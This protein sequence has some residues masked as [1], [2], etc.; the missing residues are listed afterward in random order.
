MDLAIE[1]QPT[2]NKGCAL[3]IKKGWCDMR[4][5]NKIVAL[6]V[7][8]AFAFSSISYA[9]ETK[10]KTLGD[11]LKQG[12]SDVYHGKKK[13]GETATGIIAEQ[14]QQK[15]DEAWKNSELY[16]FLFSH[17]TF[18]TILF[19]VSGFYWGTLMLL[20]ASMLL[21]YLIKI[22][23]KRRSGFNWAVTLIVCYPILRIVYFFVEYNLRDDM[24]WVG[25]VS[26]AI[27]A[28]FIIIK[29]KFFISLVLAFSD[30][31]PEG[32]AEAWR[33]DIKNPPTPRTADGD[34]SDDD[35]ELPKCQ[36]CGKNGVV[37]G[38]CLLCGH[39]V[40]NDEPEDDEDDTADLP[41]DRRTPAPAAPPARP[42]LRTREERLAEAKR[43]R[44]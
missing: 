10:K 28:V 2:T 24:K 19:W 32:L 21:I 4:T 8:T 18:H 20:L 7:L 37:N 11:S 43:L 9:Q 40:T 1:Q 15:S 27:I 42:K 39:V 22:T 30:D 44:R 33:M 35:A 23:G 38:S 17:D 26:I 14:A 6:I 5:L 29:I 25:F 16:G 13:V 41:E 31:G 34:D 36:G 3:E 12:V